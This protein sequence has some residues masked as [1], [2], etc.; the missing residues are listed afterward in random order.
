[1]SKVPII[2]TNVGGLKDKV[3]NG[4]NGYLVDKENKIDNFVNVINYIYENPDLIKEMKKNI[5]PKKFLN[6][7]NGFGDLLLNYYLENLKN[8]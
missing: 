1:M 2:A 6:K 3:E 8:F 5:N 4:I 7:S